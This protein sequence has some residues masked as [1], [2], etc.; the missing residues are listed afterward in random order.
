M[1]TRC[2]P[3]HP[4]LPW[5]LGVLPLHGILLATR[6]HMG[7]RHPHCYPMPSLLLFAYWSLTALPSDGL[8]LSWP[9][10]NLRA[11]RHPSFRPALSWS[12]ESLPKLDALLTVWCPDHCLC[13]PGHS[14]ASQPQDVPWL[15]S[16]LLTAR[17]SPDFSDSSLN[18]VALLGHL[19]SLWLFDVLLVRWHHH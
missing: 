5:L 16:A 19:A 11:A 4:A 1:A 8:M 6:C 17:Q 14:A 10:D 12:L 2:P 9:L 15:L 7:T 18:L 13:S 3:N